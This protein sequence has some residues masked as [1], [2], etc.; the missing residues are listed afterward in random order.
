MFLCFLFFW[1]VGGGGL[2][3]GGGVGGAGGRGGGGA[4]PPHDI[5]NTKEQTLNQGDEAEVERNVRGN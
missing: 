5:P 3:W 1:F 4:P 2:G